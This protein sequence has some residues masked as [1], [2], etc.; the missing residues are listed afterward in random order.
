MDEPWD[1]NVDRVV[2][3]LCSLERSW[4]PPSA[5]NGLCFPNTLE[6]SLREQEVDGHTLLTYDHID[7]C[8]GLGLKILKHKATLNHAIGQFR[9][10]SQ[11]YRLYKKRDIWETE[12]EDDRSQINGDGRKEDSLPKIASGLPGSSGPEGIIPRSDR[13]TSIPEPAAAKKRRVMPTNVSRT[14]DVDAIRTIPTEAD[15]ITLPAPT[16]MNSNQM[17]DVSTDPT[18]SYLGDKPLSRVTVLHDFSSDSAEDDQ[19]KRTGFALNTCGKIPNGKRIQVHKLMKRKLI[20]SH[21]SSLPAGRRAKSDMLRGANN[22]DDDEVLPPYGE[23]DEEYDTETWLEIKAEEKEREKIRN[24]PRLSHDE[25]EAILNDAIRQFAS[26]WKERKCSKLAREAYGVWISSRGARLKWS[27]ERY[28]RDRDACESRIAKVREQMHLQPWHTKEELDALTPSLQASVEDRERAIWALGVVT[29][30][31]VPERFPPVPR[32]VNKRQ[33][34]PESAVADGEES[35]TDES[36]YELDKFV[37]NEPLYYEDNPPERS[38]VV[39]RDENRQDEVSRDF[40]E[41]DA[42]DSRRLQKD[43]SIS[44]PKTPAKSKEPYVIDLITPERPPRTPSSYQSTARGSASGATKAKGKTLV[45]QQGISPDPTVDADDIEEDTMAEDLEMFD[46]SGTE[47]DD[48]IPVVPKR[49]RKVTHNQDAEDLRQADKV[50]KA[51]QDRRREVLRARNRVLNASK[52]ISQQKIII[53]ESKYDDQGFV[54][55][56]PEIAQRIKEHQVDGVRFMWDRIVGSK[57]QNRQ[58]EGQ[59]CLLAHTMGLGKSMQVVTLLVAI[60]EAA[61]SGDES[62]SSQIPDHLRQSKTL[63]LVP[64]SLVDNWIDEFLLWAPQGHNLGDFF[65]VDSSAT[66]FER[67][68]T[69]LAWDQRGGVL[70]LSYHLFKRLVEG[71]GK[72]DDVLRNGP[73]LVVSD[74]AHALKNPKSKVHVACMSFRTKSRLALTGSPL[75]NNVEEYHAMIN[76]VAPHYLSDLSEFRQTYAI[77]I[78]EGFKEDSTAYQRRQALKSLAALREQVAPKV[79]RITIAVLKSEMPTKQEFVLTVPLTDIQW[80]AYET[81]VRHQNE[82]P[83]LKSSSLAC[84][85][86][87]G[88]ICSHPMIFMRKLKS[89]RSTEGDN[90]MQS[91]PDDLINTEMRLLLKKGDL[92]AYSLSWK[93]QI[94]VS[95][96][97]ECKRV[98]DTALVF[99][100]SIPTLDYLEHVLQVEKFSYR[101]LDGDTAV[102]QRQSI[103]KE[104]AK[105]DVDVFL[106]STRAGGLGLNMTAANRVIIFDAKFNPQNEMQAVGR[107]YR[108]GQE[109]PVFVYRLVCGGTAE[110]KILNLAIWKMQLASRVVDKKNPIPKSK[111]FGQHLEMPT[112]PEQRDISAHL[113]KDNILDKVVEAHKLGIN[114][115]VMMDTFEEEEPTGD[116]ILTVEDRK[117]VQRRI[118]EETAR[119]QGK[120]GS[121]SIGPIGSRTSSFAQIAASY[122]VPGVA[123]SSNPSRTPPPTRV[124][125]PSSNGGHHAASQG[126]KSPPRNVSSFPE[127][128]GSSH[129]QEDALRPIPGATTHIG[130]SLS[131]PLDHQAFKGQL[132]RLLSDGDDSDGRERGRR[133]ARDITTAI[134]SQDK[135]PHDQLESAFLK[136][137]KNA[138]FA[139]GL[140]LGLVPMSDLIY[141]GTESVMAQE[142]A[143]GDM[144]EGEW[145]ALGK[146][147]RDQSK[148]DPQ[149]D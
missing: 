47:S 95:I 70:I 26:S 110:D 135:Y 34:P 86:S 73:N 136:A 96:L 92:S 27:I 72:L 130:K 46:K 133:L 141:N 143:W 4:E 35:L 6:I 138:R 36:E 15:M 125:I 77:P 97:Q 123:P 48:Q 8:R 62:I 76:W 55:V 67:K 22:P 103:V 45:E 142:K 111:N 128:S 31:T 63:F 20:G 23:S 39:T 3:E 126:M 106:I 83:E 132:T 85:D 17:A 140:R 104:F 139:E 74:E 112:K 54:Y 78:K 64:A 75:A 109:K 61:K 50:A 98:E 88:A 120:P 66:Y 94:L 14:I 7:L 10:R 33:L 148:A 137:A 93:V 121:N 71:G 44:N 146:T 37:D 38:A 105:G 80:E 113:G 119:R 5:Q 84:I 13:E 28:H 124:A 29:S 115:I 122:S 51:E 118:A 145:E 90:K 49:R 52:P 87:L 60:S 108:L 19:I 114:S 91:L 107:A 117:E 42:I 9:S 16:P 65:K 69:I 127:G 144:E 58:L 18:S 79:Q 89:Q 24:R 40:S 25:V 68:E 99:S 147:G 30:P 2:Q 43:V 21:R 41:T 11:R 57:E 116:G 131:L 149:S 134:N 81:F 1:W 129:I 102:N 12:T 56:N 59:G 100:H 101:R 32:T 82:H 53:N